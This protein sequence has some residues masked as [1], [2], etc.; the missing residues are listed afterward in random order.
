MEKTRRQYDAKF[1]SMVAIEAIKERETLSEL[2]KRFE[3]SPVVICRWKKEFL[4]NAAAAFETS[5]KEVGKVKEIIAERDQYLRK[6]G[7]LEMELDFA[8]RVSRRLGIA[9]PAKNSFPR[10]RQNKRQAAM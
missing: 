1:K 10:E 5:Q 9:V 4:S 3:I 7:E 8:E 6:I 2:S